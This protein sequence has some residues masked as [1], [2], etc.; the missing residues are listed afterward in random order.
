[1][2]YFDAHLSDMGPDK[3]LTD[4]LSAYKGQIPPTFAEKDLYRSYRNDVELRSSLTNL[5][6]EKRGSTLPSLLI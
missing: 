5:P 2:S 1:M 6:P 3:T 4:V